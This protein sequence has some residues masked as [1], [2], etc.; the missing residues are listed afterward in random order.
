MSST[1]KFHHRS[2]FS[3]KR[4]SHKINGKSKSSSSSLSST[5]K[6]FGRIDDNDKKKNNNNKNNKFLH[7]NQFRDIG[8]A[9]R[10]AISKEKRKIHREK[11]IKNKLKYY[12][13]KLVG[14]IPKVIVLIALSPYSNTNKIKKHF[15]KYCG[16]ECND[17]NDNN[18]ND[19]KMTQCQANIG[20]KKQNFIIYQCSNRDDIYSIFDICKIADIILLV[21]SP[22]PFLNN[23]DNDNDNDNDN[24]LGFDDKSSLFCS[25]IR[26]IGGGGCGGIT[27]YGLYQTKFH[28]NLNNLKKNNKYQQC[29]LDPLIKNKFLNYLNHQFGSNSNNSKNIRVFNCY[30]MEQIFRFMSLTKNYNDLKSINCEWKQKRPHLLIQNIKNYDKN[31][32]ILSVDGYLRGTVKLNI[33]RPIHIS[34]IDD[35]NNY[36][37]LIKQIDG[38]ISKCHDNN[39]NNNN[40]NNDDDKKDNDTVMNFI[41]NL[42]DDDKND[43]DETVT[44]C[45]ANIN[46]RDKLE[47]LS[48][49][50]DGLSTQFDQTIITENEL[51]EIE[52]EREKIIEKEKLEKQGLSHY[53]MDFDIDDDD[54]I[55]IDIDIEQQ[56]NDQ[57]E[58]E[59]NIDKDKD[60]EFL[61]ND[62]VETPINVRAKDRFAQYRGLK[63]FY[64][65][66]WDKFELL[67]IEYS[68]IS[69]IK[70]WKKAIKMTK[71]ENMIK[72]EKENGLIEDNDNNNNNNNNLIECG[73]RV[74]IYIEG[75]TMDIY[76]KILLNFN[77]NKPLIIWSLLKFENKISVCH[78]LIKKQK[79]YKKDMIGLNEYIFDVGFR[80]FKCNPIFSDNSNGNKHLIKKIIIN[81]DEFMIASIYGYINYPPLPLT[82]YDGDNLCATGKLFSI[83][84]HRILIKRKILTGSAI[85]VQKRRAIIKYMFNNCFDVNYFK[86][87]DLWTKHGLKGKIEQGIGDKGLMKC[88]F[89]GNIKQNDTI[90]LSLYKRIFPFKN[91]K[92]FTNSCNH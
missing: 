2:T 27:I 52:Q 35:I 45:K 54:D 4:K 5:K 1:S 83:N 19:K 46:N 86:P 8:K 67:P 81:N 73:K 62:Q 47:S 76:N 77:L 85:K 26:N 40:R 65:T 13:G 48:A 49:D 89:N 7:C 42:D 24:I 66:K 32:K 30:D 23:N 37:F 61:N 56:E 11:L 10:K 36:H 21:S 31:N 72:K 80:R 28:K 68:Q 84:A 12:G 91:D 55:D 16:I 69:N 9:Q 20:N 70:D 29:K 34:G 74:R 82:V 3:N 88:F 22:S 38:L 59:E 64:K 92:L 78:Y 79:N 58:N 60:F 39:N 57:Q 87:I 51:K 63:Q 15:L 50:L 33:N 90:C 53:N 17:S 14:G 6:V 75:I 71:L 43:D 18:D 25:L 44:L 41:N